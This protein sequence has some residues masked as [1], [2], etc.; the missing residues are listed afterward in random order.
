MVSRKQKEERERQ[1]AVLKGAGRLW[2]KE[3]GI[4]R[5]IT[6][7]KFLSIVLLIATRGGSIQA[8]LAVAHCASRQNVALTMNAK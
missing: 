3:L 6:G 8:D 1:T 4:D 7:F 5:R 2:K